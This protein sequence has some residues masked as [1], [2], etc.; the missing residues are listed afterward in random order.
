MIRELRLADMIRSLSDAHVEFLVF[1]AVAAAL[2]G[3]IRATRDLDI[4]LAPDPE[5]VERLI[6]WLH[7]HDARPG[8]APDEQLSERHL[9]QL[10]MG[11][12]AWV[13]TVFGELDV[14]QHIDGL[15]PWDELIGRAEAVRVDDMDLRVVDRETLIARKRA[16]ATPQDLVDAAA[17]EALD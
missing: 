7:D 3:Y 12:N 13:A 9:R 11:R 14:V 16:R 5:N 2:Y 15:P 10:R 17:L 1:G 4:V 8:N 6:R